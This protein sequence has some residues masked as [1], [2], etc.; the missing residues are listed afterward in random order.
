M[1]PEA[2]LTDAV[3]HSPVPRKGAAERIL[4]RAGTTDTDPTAFA[5]RRGCNGRFLAT[6]VSNVYPG[7]SL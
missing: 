6:R 4:L 7:T 3:D 5:V 2:A 1:S